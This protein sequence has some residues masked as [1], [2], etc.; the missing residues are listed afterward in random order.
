L[1]IHVDPEVA[2]LFE[3]AGKLLRPRAVWLSLELL[4]FFTQ[5]SRYALQFLHFRRLR[6]LG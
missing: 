6:L 5:D 1:L 4:E 3:Q 2:A